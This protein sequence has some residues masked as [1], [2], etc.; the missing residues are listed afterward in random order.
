MPVDKVS[1]EKFAQSIKAKYPQYKDVEDTLLT[2]SIIQKYPEYKDMVDF[3]AK[4]AVAQKVVTTPQPVPI[5]AQSLRDLNTQANKPVIQDVATAEDVG[6]GGPQPDQGQ[7]VAQQDFD[8]GLKEFSTTLGVE[9]EHVQKAI[10]DFPQISD[11]GHLKELATISKENPIKYDRLSAADK[12]RQMIA[13]SGIPGAIHAAND[14]NHLQDQQ[15]HAQLINN[16]NAQKEIINTTLSGDERIKAHQNLEREKAPLI[17]SLSPGIQKDYQSSKYNTILDPNQYSGL[18]ELKIFRPEFYDQIVKELDQD[19]GIKK[20]TPADLKIGYHGSENKKTVQADAPQLL[21]LEVIK[22]S[23]SDIGR[24]NLQSFLQEKA[25]DLERQYKNAFTNSTSSDEEKRDIQQQYIHYKKIADDLEKDKAQ[26]DERYPRLTAMK[27]DEAVREQT[28]NPKFNPLEYG[29]YRFAK[30]IENTGESAENLFTGLFAGDETNTQLAIKRLG[31]GRIGQN[32]AF[33]PTKLRHNDN[34]FSKATLYSNAGM[35]G[36]IASIAAQSA[37][38]GGAGAGKILSAALPMFTTSQNEFYKEAL[39]AGDPNP[40]AKANVNALIMSAAGLINPDLNI[41]KRSLGVSTVAGKAL[42]GIDEATWKSVIEKNKPLL[43][44]IQNSLTS[45]AKEAGKLGLLYG[46]GTSIARDLANKELFNENISGEDIVN[47]AVQATKDLALSSVALLGVHAISNFKAV[48]P[49]QKGAIWEAGQHP[50]YAI[51]AIDDALRKGEIPQATADLRKQAVKDIS[52]MINKVPT[53]NKKGK[54]LSDKD[55]IDYLYNMIV[56]KKAKALTENLPEAQKEDVTHTAL[57]ADYKNNLILEPKTDAQLESRKRKLE[58]DLEPPKVVEGKKEPEKLSDKE[59]ASAKAELEA[60][61]DI[62]DQKTKQNEAEAKTANEAKVLSNEGAQHVPSTISVIQPG[63]INRP[64]TTIIKPQENSGNKEVVEA[65]QRVID[66]DSPEKLKGFPP[67]SIMHFRQGIDNNTV[68]LI[69]D[70]EVKEQYSAKSKAWKKMSGGGSS[71]GMKHILKDIA[72]NYRESYGKDKIIDLR[73]IDMSKSLPDI[74]KELEHKPE[75]INQN[76][77]SIGKTVN[78]Q[79]KG[80]GK[81]QTNENQLSERTQA[82]SGS[83]SEMEGNRS[84]EDIKRRMEASGAWLEGIARNDKETVG[85]AEKELLRESDATQTNQEGRRALLD[86]NERGRA[87]VRTSGDNGGNI[88]AKTSEQGTRSSQ[89]RERPEQSSGQSGIS[90][91]KTASTDSPSGAKARSLVK[92]ILRMRD[93]QKDE[94]SARG[95][96]EVQKM[97]SE[98]PAHKEE[99]TKIINQEINNYHAVSKSIS[100]TLGPHSGGAESIGGQSE[101]SGV[102]QREQGPPPTGE[103]QPKEGG[104]GTGEE[105]VISTK[106]AVTDALRE[107]HGLP[108]VEIPKD[109]STDESL[110][111]WRDGTRHPLQIVDQL[112]SGKSIYDKSITP[113]DEPIM[114]EYIRGLNNRG[115]ELNKANEALSER[116]KVGDTEAIPKQASVQQQ[117]LNHYDEMQRALDAERIGG[118]IWHKYGEERQIAVNEQGQIINSINRI[119]TIY[120]DDMPQVMKDKLSA[121]QQQYDALVAKNSKIEEALKQKEAENELLKQN[122]ANKGK[123]KSRKSSGDFAKERK[124]ILSD[125]KAAI[126]KVRGNTYAAI[127]GTPELAAIAPHVLKLFR[128]FGEE[129]TY[130]LSDIIDDIHEFAKEALDGITKENIRDIIAGK[131]NEKKPLSELN[132]KLNDLR[133]QAKIQTKIEDLENGISISQKKNGEGSPELQ[134]LKAELIETKKQ[135]L[136]EYAHLSAEQLKKEAE[137]IQRQINKGDYFKMPVVKKKWENDPEW[138]KND[139]RKADLKQELRN[140]VQKAYDS[141]KS[142]YMRALDWTNRWGRRVIF[143]GA[144]AV[145]TKLSSAAVLGSFVHREL[146]QGLG[147]VNKKLYPHIAKNAPI[148]GNINAAAEAKFYLEFLNLKKFGQNIWSQ[149]R[150]GE[151]P[152]SKELGRHSNEKH[153][154]IV[155]LFAADAHAM[156]KDPVKRA[157]FEAAVMNHLRFYA[158]NNIDGTHPLMLESARQAA[159][160]AAEYEIFQNSNNKGKGISHFFNELEKT[161]IVNNNMPDTWSKVKGN[162]QYTAASLYH[163]FVPINTVPTN[164]LNRVGL[165]LKT[166]MTMVKAMNNNKAIRDGIMNM[167]Q[168]ESDLIMRQLKKGQVGTAYWTLGFILGGSVVGG[169]YTKY[170]PDKDR[171]G[172]LTNELL[173]KGHNVPKDVQHNTQLQSLQMGGTWKTVYSHYINDKGA[174]QMKALSA[175]TAATAGAALESVPTAEM[176]AKAYE[177]AKTPGGGEKFIK[178][179]KRRVGVDK[180]TNLAKLMGYQSTEETDTEKQQEKEHQKTVTKLNEWRTKLKITDKAILPS[181]IQYDHSTPKPNDVQTKELKGLIEESRQKLFKEVTKELDFEKMSDS[182]KKVALETVMKEGEETGKEAFKTKYPQFTPKRPEMTDEE[183]EK[184]QEQSEKERDIQRKIANKAREMSAPK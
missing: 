34:L 15:D 97:L 176:A 142:K 54:P 65:P 55:R 141:K 50:D 154:P 114:R 16:I 128:S 172:P 40:M 119:K 132:K 125:M 61:N 25:G 98:S 163:F 56:T 93:M 60:I 7:A 78:S 24:H 146:E 138:I 127:P 5:T 165:G 152:L 167:T 77:I 33:L 124:D 88:G 91:S 36:D 11:E 139:R 175:A 160:K 63:E 151:T 94:I 110:N 14:Y 181:D 64:E 118:N 58:S 73:G 101:G 126:K 74:I 184:Q 171:S 99:I 85:N 108:P 112:L 113:N 148:E 80:Y 104:E 137:T 38:L 82:E 87:E 144:N 13:N 134:K 131:Y 67:E 122:Q 41:V 168:E 81:P 143:F 133:S 153:I 86:N 116:V 92:E 72:K 169:L 19:E 149:A 155:D 12:N 89:G 123:E 51:E 20:E 180:A 48:S 121:M 17:N 4:P 47:H 37:A 3:N 71:S 59:K 27:L 100:R 162:A 147:L 52:G 111:A 90:N 129:A 42:Q 183:R 83:N 46:A 23:L 8:K 150:Y 10:F 106:N 174:S 62:L 178:D 170:D 1:I 130:K 69:T 30:G 161:G 173:I 32:E 79:E 75:K 2:N 179:L 156:I 103:G 117:L 6:A 109:R 21:G 26:D 164:I 29:I 96:R 53:E 166:P 57:V 18:E 31:E 70:P 68:T 182:E 95:A 44:K 22:K 136:N 45:T 145:Y 120:G 28:N 158:D 135:S 9:P 35:I 49:Q 39:E 107:Q 157:T 159:Y 76:A 105:K 115:I 66:F 102:G 43:K 177:A 84:P 140:L